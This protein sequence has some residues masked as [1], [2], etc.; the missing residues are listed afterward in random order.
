MR[1]A[2]AVPQSRLVWRSGLVF[3]GLL[4]CGLSDDPDESEPVDVTDE[5]DE[6]EPRR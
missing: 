2:S 3:C 6:L 1:A 4:P 5:L